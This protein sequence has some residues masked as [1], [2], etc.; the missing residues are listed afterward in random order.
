MVE[1]NDAQPA[2]TGT[3][4][5]SYE[6]LMQWDELR[7]FLAGNYQE[8]ATIGNFRIFERVADSRAPIR[9]NP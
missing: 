9:M 5:G 3:S 1:L 6:Y 8:L 7:S 2:V 4:I